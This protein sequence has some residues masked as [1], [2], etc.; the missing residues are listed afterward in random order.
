MLI[1]LACAS[2]VPGPPRWSAPQ[3]TPLQVAESLLEAD[4]AFAVSAARTD[5]LSTLS[6]MFADSV[7][8]PLPQSGFAR[9]KAAVLSALSAMP[10]GAEARVTWTPI[11]VGISA[12]ATHGFTFGYLTLSSPDSSRVSRKYMAYWVSDAGRWRAL[13]Y[14]RGRAPGPAASVAMM[15]PALPASIVTIRDDAPR[16]ERL[17]HELMHAKNSFSLTA[18]RV[19][20]GNAFAALGVADAVNM[21]GSASATFSVGAQTIAEGA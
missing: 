17:R 14:K 6:T 3:R 16:D 5:M 4:R 2:I 1:A 21:G 8:M 18:Q 9:G 15:P 13:A 10:R 11:R 12:D 7:I 20:V 19:G